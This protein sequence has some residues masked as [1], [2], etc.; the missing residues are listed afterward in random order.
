LPGEGDSP[1]Q[2]SDRTTREIAGDVDDQTDNGNADGLGKLNI[3]GGKIRSTEV[4][5]IMAETPSRN[6]ALV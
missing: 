2:S 1:L 3:S 6:R 4:A 5:A